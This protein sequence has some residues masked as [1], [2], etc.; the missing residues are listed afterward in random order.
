VVAFVGVAVAKPWGTPAPAATQDGGPTPS[1]AAP[2]SQAVTVAPASATPA[3][4]KPVAVAFITPVPPPAKAVWTGIR[5]HRL[6]PDDPL[7]HVASVLRWRGGFLAVGWEVSEGT[8]TTPVWTS[9]DGAH[10]DPLP[11]DTSTTFWPGMSIVGVAEA[12]TGLVVLTEPG[13]GSSCSDSPCSLGYGPPTMSW[14]SP[15]GRTWSPSLSLDLGLPGPAADE[16]M[17]AAGPAGL[18]AMSSGP[19]ALV[20]TSS[21]GVKWRTLPD[22]TLPKVFVAA[23]LRATATGYV[24]GGRWMTSDSHWDAATLWSPDGR[25]WTPTPALPLAAAPSPVPTGAGTSSVVDLFVAG[26]NGLI[27]MGRGVPNPGAE[28]WWQSTDG[29]HWRPLP[30]YLPLGPTTCPGPDCGLRAN[31]ALVGDGERMVALRGGS[32]AGVW[33]SYDGLAWSRL[34]VT[35]DL[36]SERATQAVLLPGGVLLSDGTSFWFGEAVVE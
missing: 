8:T 29:R 21:D 35:G 26:R 3:A 32:D 17:L 13:V 19:G 18:I 10:W 30:T 36:P 34:P 11:F 31:G 5:W 6:A 12:P 1:Q 2:A 33:T 4:T 22:G 27:A 9:A 16:P 7:T 20:A 23:D 15:D 24:A 25:A 14:T 28:L